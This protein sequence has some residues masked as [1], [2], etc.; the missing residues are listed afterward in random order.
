MQVPEVLIPAEHSKD[1][2][3]SF[4]SPPHIQDSPNFL[5]PHATQQ[6]VASP[7]PDI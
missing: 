2:L 5:K 4:G 3:P 6:K 7:S 1:F